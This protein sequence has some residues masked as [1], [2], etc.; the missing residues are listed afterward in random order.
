MTQLY[1]L[2]S[3]RLRQSGSALTSKYICQ[4]LRPLTW[5]AAWW[6]FFRLLSFLD[7]PV[8]LIDAVVPF[9]R[10][11]LAALVGWLAFQLIDLITAICTNSE[12]LRPHRNLSEMIVPVLV[13]TLKGAV[14]LLVLTDLIYQVGEGESLGQ[15]LTGL[16]VAGLTVS[17]AAQ[18]ALKSFFGTLLLISE[19]SFRLG[20]RI[21]VGGKEGVVEQVG[22]RST[23]LRTPE[24][25]LLT[26]PNAT[27]AS[28]GIDNLGVRSFQPYQTSVFISY[29][30]SFEELARFRDQ[31]QEWLARQPGIDKD[32]ADISIQGFSQ[33]G[34]ELRVNLQLVSAGGVEEKQVRDEINCAV[35][36]LAQ[37]MEIGLANAKKPMR[38]SDKQEV[39]EKTPPISALPGRAA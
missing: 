24:G 10:F 13:R 36:R 17:L 25:S 15:F 1:R 38:G 16:G 34:V 9:K 28:A 14:I 21:N 37:A 2:T 27:I 22:F 29:E 39:S 23:R 6:L 19:R 3:W 5:V 12:L 30:T 33:H 31:L 18:D 20:D 8:G 4:K 26:I 35:L 32:K 11:V 7:L